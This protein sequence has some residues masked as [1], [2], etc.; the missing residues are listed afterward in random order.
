MLE[1]IEIAVL[2]SGD[3]EGLTEKVALQ[4]RLIESEGKDHLDVWRKN[5]QVE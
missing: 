3:R 4:E 2:E 5:L 1:G